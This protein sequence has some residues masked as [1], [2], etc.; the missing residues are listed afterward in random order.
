MMGLSLA[1]T[2]FVQAQQ[3]TI[4]E[5]L[6]EIRTRM[7]KQ[8]LVIEEQHI[9]DSVLLDISK[10]KLNPPPPPVTPPVQPPNRQEKTDIEKN[11][12]IEKKEAEKKEAEKKEV[13]KIEVEK[14][15]IE[16]KEINTDS[17]TRND[18]Q[19]TNIPKDNK[20][21]LETC[22]QY[23]IDNNIH[24]KQLQLEQ[25][26]AEIQ[27]NTAEN[28]RLPD[29]NSSFG[30]NWT[31]G[32][33]QDLLGDFS[34]RNQS[35]TALKAQSTIPVF[36]G[37]RISNEIARTK[38]NVQ[39]AVKNLE[40][41]K[42]DLSLTITSLFLQV[43]FSKEL[44]YINEKQYE[45]GISQIERT[46]LLIQAGNVPKSQ[47]YDIEA[48]VAKDEVSVIDAQNNLDLALLDFAQ[49]LELERN[50]EFDI[51]VPNIGGDII[52]TY[53]KSLQ[54]PDVIYENA[55]NT[56]PII[57][58]QEYRVE[59]ARKNLKIAESGYYPQ[60]DFSMGLGTSI[61]HVSK[62]KEQI[63]P[64]TNQP[65]DMNPPVSTQI[66]NY[67]S[68]IFGFNVN[69]PIFNRYQVRNQARSAKIDILNQQ[70][71]LENNKKTLY[72]E[73]QTAYKN[74]TAAL[75]KYRSS[76]RAV[77]SANESFEYVRRRYELGNA[78]V[79]EFNESRTRLIQSQS[80][81]AQAKYEYI[82]R[83]KIL[84]FYNGIPIK[85]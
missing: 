21:S 29:L 44:Y 58:G 31:Y 14:I 4:Q 34:A 19:T 7:N 53:A 27:H 2:G 59:S 1:F 56:K 50:K 37:F 17:I 35:Q 26:D 42:E 62:P 45:L 68:R 70:L 48:Q 6:Q 18:R 24:I 40:K 64:I 61:Y 83:T 47:L 33:A 84:D 28:S 20:W 76:E 78:T 46:K 51:Y 39:A 52:D 23:A 57:K 67:G 82:L 32:Q 66:G 65:I 12:V 10:D 80:E 85:L 9:I 41:A 8:K 60:I 55:L 11:E 49:N 15:E 43:L 71:I 72:K 54:P 16:K 13:E 69:I 22:I 75:E 3:K 36:T 77:K 5:E 74:A 81:Q 30:L 38:L 25:E 79:F 63:N 73:I